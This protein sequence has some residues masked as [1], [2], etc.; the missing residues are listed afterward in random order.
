MHFQ[1]L[2]LMTS[3]GGALAIR[4]EWAEAFRDIPRVY[5]CFDRDDAGRRGTARLARLIPQVRLVTL[6]ALRSHLLANTY[7]GPYSTGETTYA[8]GF[9]R[10]LPDI[11]GPWPM[12]P[13]TLVTMTASLRLPFTALPRCSSETP[14]L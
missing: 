1:S 14:L 9:W 6:M 3:T 5:V 13:P 2:P 10:E 7:F 4:P 12:P 8:D 11:F